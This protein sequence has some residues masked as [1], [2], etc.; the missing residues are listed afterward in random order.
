MD[1]GFH[2]P[3][4]SFPVAGTLMVEPTESES[5]RRARSVLRRDDRDPRR[6]PGDRGGPCEPPAQCAQ[7]STAHAGAGRRRASGIVPTAA[8]RR[9]FRRRGPARTSSG[10]LLVV[11]TRPSAIARWCVPVRRSKRTR[12]PHP[13]P[14][15]ELR[16]SMAERRS[17]AHRDRDVSARRAAAADQ[18][19]GPCT[20]AARRCGAVRRAHRRGRLC[21]RGTCGVRYQGRSQET[22]GGAPVGAADAA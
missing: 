14:W 20:A 21:R 9:R 10:R 18:L 7:A 5:T 3:T 11:S 19:R 4:V 22:G 15:A 17:T 16:R 6:D 12:R 1:Y 8:R 2:A 13:L